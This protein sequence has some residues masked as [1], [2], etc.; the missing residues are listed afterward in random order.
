MKNKSNLLHNLSKIIL[1]SIGKKRLD[2]QV[3]EPIISKSAE[4]H[5]LRCIKSNHVSS[6]GE[7]LNKFEDKLKD[8]TGSKYIVLTNSGT[9]ALFI[10]LKQL[11]VEKCEVLTPSMTFAATSN[12]IVYNDAIPH[13]I[14]SMKSNPCID[15]DKL[16]LYLSET[17]IIKKN[18]C[19]NKVSKRKIKALVV[20]HAFGYTAEMSKLIKLCN[21]YNIKILEDA[22][23][24]LGSYYKN[25]HVGTFSDFGILSFNGNKI[26]TTG[27]GGA[28]LMKKH[29]DYKMVKHLI[30]TARLKHPYEIEHDKVGYNLRMSNINAAL[31]Y[32][33]LLSLKTTLKKKKILCEKYISNIS[34]AELCNF[35]IEN[36]S[37]KQNNWV[38][39]L[40]IKDKYIN[41]RSDIFNHLHSKGIKCRAAW[42][43]QHLLQM[44]LNYPK[45]KTDNCVKLWKSIISLPSSYI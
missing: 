11:E 23:G 24:A 19:Y 7:Y 14:D 29:K 35:I 4:T 37:S 31:G 27:M 26:V 8:I 5:M 36:N 15:V 45:M 21:K 28:I 25:K 12:A 40:I 42:K 1:L 43:P 3:H 22:A 16:A 6:S 18:F 20:V 38:N 32:S 2:Y 17:C 44:N 39:N 10:S 34:K 41:M 30:S 13:Y 33:Q 9:A